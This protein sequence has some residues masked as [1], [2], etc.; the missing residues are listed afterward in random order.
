[1]RARTMAERSAPRSLWQMT[2]ESIP[3]DTHLPEQT[4]V[5][6]VGGGLAGVTTALMLAR[7]GIDVTLLEAGRIGGLTTGH[8]TAKL[9]A[10]Q[11]SVY[12]S[13]HRHNGD[14]AVRDYAAATVDAHAWLRSELAE[15][16]DIDGAV[17]ERTALTYATTDEGAATL[18]REAEALAI[19]GIDAQ[20]CAAGDVGLPFS[21]RGALRL[22]AQHQLQPLAALGLLA[23]RARALGAR[24]IESA[25]VR[26]ISVADEQVTIE[27][28]RGTLRAN[29]VVVATGLPILDRGLFFTH[30]VPTR[31]YVV[32]V[33]VPGGARVLPMSL[34]VDPVERS[35]RDARGRDN[36][37]L[38]VVGGNSFTPGRDDDT[39]SRLDDAVAWAL[40]TFPGATVA[41][42]WAAQDY[43]AEH[44]VPFAGP[45]PRGS[46][47]IWAATGFAK[48]GMTGAVLAARVIAGQLTDSTPPWAP[49]FS[50]H[51]GS[52]RTV[53]GILGANAAVA[54]ELIVG[55]AR[56]TPAAPEAPDVG[57]ERVVPVARDPQSQGCA[58]R[59]VCT[60]LGGVLRWN[61]AEQSW[62]CPLHGSR[63]TRDGQVIEGPATRDLS[64]VDDTDTDTILSDEPKE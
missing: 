39:A 51:R 13:I 55:W 41:T 20:W 6:V 56:P 2:A 11:G 26:D 29:R 35:L 42:W 3:T 10:L 62:D 8:T 53:G 37:R 16:A 52:A 44:H 45:M 63:F 12:G 19:A 38:I 18:A 61:T 7:A 59:L 27:S 58:L 43:Q 54:K 47:R 33:S 15:L 36:E 32:A 57:R 23:R 64:R 40:S 14:D 1:M 46:G 22:P 17:E 4:D 48:W 34:S 5:A 28:D 49:T 21:V 50:T 60:H 30:M 31:Q 9:S 24:L 25:R